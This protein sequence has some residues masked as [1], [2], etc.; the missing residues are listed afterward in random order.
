MF[1]D[2][3]WA[4]RTDDPR[5]RFG[6]PPAGNANFAWLQHIVSKLAECGSAGVV[7]A[8][9][10]MSSQ[11]SG[12]GQIRAAMV[13]ADLVACIIATPPQLFPT[14]AISPC[15]RFLAQDKTPPGRQR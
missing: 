7:L 6:T 11:Q 10:S 12:E 1:N 4:R 3:D 5:W 8:N 14:P 2:S 15:L 9:A 13:E